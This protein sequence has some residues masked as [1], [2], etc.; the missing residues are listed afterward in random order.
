VS[1]PVQLRPRKLLQSWKEIA[2]HL[3]V[4]V[5]TVQRWEKEASLPIHRQGSGRKARVVGYSDELDSWL[6]PEKNQEPIPAR[7]SR[8]FYWPVL[9]VLVVGIVGAGLWFAFRGQPQPKGVALE[10]DRLKILDAARHVLWE[11]SF[12]PLNHLQYTQCDSTLIIDLD[13]DA[14]SEVLFNMIPAPGSAKTGKLFCYESDGRLRWSFAY[15]RERVIAGRSINGQFMG[16][17]FRVV[18]AGSRRLIL[19]VANH[20]LWFPSQV[21]LLDPASGE[22]VDEYWHPGHFFS[23]LVQDLDGDRTDELLLAGINNPGQGLGHGALAV[24]KMPFSRAK[25]QAG[26]EAS[27]FFELT[28]GKEHAYLLFPKLDASE[29][30]GKLP[31]IREIML[32]SDKRI[33]IRLTAEEIQSFYS[34]DFNLRLKDTRFTDN[35]VSLHDRLSSLGLLK[36]KISEKELASLRRVEYFPT[37]PDGNSPEIIKR[38]QALP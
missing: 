38:L 33:Q 32:T 2:N 21:A 5:R 14:T 4:T 30:E 34:L 10:G 19:T 16:V 29:V 22:L 13:G 9:I 11:Q 15:G 8:A 1:S 37:A 26:A 24:L 12:P 31:I 23:L 35:L 20:Q 6:R 28:E 18:Q 25:K 17:F 36:H 7:R 27:P 3:G